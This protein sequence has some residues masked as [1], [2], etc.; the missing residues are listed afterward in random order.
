[1][2]VWWDATRSIG[3]YH[4]IGHEP[5]TEGGKV[6]LWNNLFTPQGIYRKT[7]F[8]PLRTADRIAAGFGGG[9]ET[10]R[11]D[12]DGDCV[13][14][15]RDKE[16][17]ASLRLKD[18]HPSIDCYPKSG[19]FGD[20]FAPHHL[21]VACRVAGSVTVHGTR[22]EVGGL[23]MRDHGWGPRHWRAMLS[24]RWLA[25]VFETGESLCALSFQ[26]SDDRLIKFGWIVRGDEVIYGRDI[27]IVAYMACDAVSN[28][29]GVL[30]MTL[31]TGE[32][33]EARFEAV[34]PCVM[35][36]HHGMACMDSL[37]RVSWGGRVGAGDFETSSNAQRGA[38]RPLTLDGGVNLEGWLPRT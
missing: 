36:F 38:R 28:R 10:C 12:Y 32:P 33:V 17:S 3:G 22:Y 6:A 29:G 4:R 21:E 24:H 35:A 20:D 14:T 1:M 19:S 23:G 2:L 16:L 5:N 7:H 9:D 13:W 18:F 30:N 25:G 8:V 26:G 27:D 34:T 37:C 15:V 31:T 11:F